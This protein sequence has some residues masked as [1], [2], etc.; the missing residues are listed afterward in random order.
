MSNLTSSIN[1]AKIVRV[2]PRLRNIEALLL[3]FVLGINAFELA[4][5][6]LST[7]EKVT[8]DLFLYWTP[9]AAFAGGIHMILRK[10]ARDADSM[11]LPIAVALNGLGLSE[12]YRLDLAQ[13][14]A[15]GHELFAMKQV[16]WTCVALAA[17][18][19]VIIYVPTHLFLRRFVYIAMIVGIAL[20]LL[21]ML[22]IIGK[23]INGAHLW[24]SAFGLTFQPGELAKIALTV[25]F[26]GYLVTRRDS[27]AIVGR[28]VLGVQLPRARELG[29]ILAIWGASLLVL[30]LQRDLGTSL[31][32]FG[33]FI[34]MIYVA[35]GRAIYVAVGLTMFI[36]G[37]LVASR[38][39]DYVRGRFDSWLNPFDSAHYDAVGGSYQL[40]QGIFGMAHGG[41]FGTGLGG[42]VPQLVPLAESD[43]IVA[44]LGEELGM[45]GLFAVFA[46][47]MLLVYRGVRIAFNHSDDFSK[48]LAVGLSFV[49][50]LQTFIV[51]GGVTRVVPLTGL[52][53][54]LLAAGGSSLIANWV[55]LGLLL[56]ISDSSGSAARATREANAELPTSVVNA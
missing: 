39:M 56:R 49:I 38:I 51:V 11:I 31:L 45:A 10:Y 53:T 2:V 27:L 48:L 14:A 21:P 7:I 12:I 26:A 1:I 32:Y 47:Y 6:Q 20:L 23:T 44:S 50:A 55:I 52:T 5:I 17:A 4:Q 28:K 15:G 36:T 22:P 29:P 43:F 30:V 35:T 41:I 25:F 18:A 33:L 13:I 42:G 34:V 9:L 40:V 19:A 16:V 37:A 54:P 3:I 24:I 46:L 8:T